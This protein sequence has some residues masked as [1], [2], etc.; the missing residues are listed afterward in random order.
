MKL[1]GVLRAVAVAALLACGTVQAALITIVN[2]DAPGEG[3]ND[4]TPAAPEGGNAGTT[5]GQQRFNLFQAAAAV[6][7]GTLQSNI[8]IKVGAQ[9]NPLTCS[10]TSAVL[11]SAGP[12]AVDRDFPGAPLANTWY[13]I[14]LAEALANGNRNG[15]NNEI[16]ATFNSSIDT[17]CFGNPPRRWWYGTNP[18]IPPAANTVSLFP[19]VLHELGHGLGFSTLVCVSAA[20]C[21][22]PAPQQGSLFDGRNDSWVPLLRDVSQGLNWSAMT[23]AQRVTSMTNDPN[24]VWN[25]AQVTAA[26]PTFAPTGAGVNGAGVNARMRMNA[27][28]PVVPG[29]S[30][31]HFT[32]AA[33]NPDLLME[34]SLSTGLFNQTDMTVPLF[35]DIGWQIL[36]GAANQPPVITRPAAISVTEDVAS[37]I[38]GIS[39]ADPD[40][41]GGNLTA[42]F[43]V[44]AGTFNN[45][46]CAGVTS[47]GT[48]SAR[49]LTGTLSNLN[50]CLGAGS[51]LY[52][53]AADATTSV[54]MTVTANDN[55]NTGTGGAQ[56]DVEIVSLNITA[57]NDPPVNTVPA[58]IAVTEDVATG[59]TGIS[60][61]DVDIAAGVIMVTLDVPSGGIDSPVCAG[62]GVAGSATSRRLT[63]TLAQINACFGGANRPRFTTAPN[64]AANVQL[65]VTSN[66]NGNTGT[67]N[68]GIDSDPLTLAVSA[69]NDA[70]IVTLPASIPIAVPGITPLGGI[71]VADVDSAG[72]NV[73]AT[74]AVLSG[75]LSAT[76]AGGVAVAGSSTAS[77][78]LTGTIANLAAF[79]GSSS[80]SYTAGGNTTLTVTLNDLGNTGSGGPQSTVVM[81]PLLR[82]ILFANSFE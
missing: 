41:G 2:L 82:E 62:V 63:G 47:G 40:I 13:H 17:G 79:L 10:Q 71:V 43:S 74:L 33:A 72:G 77:V 9:F 11:G 32:S 7:A 65:T 80:V 15:V 60:F 70:P 67:G 68:V 12:T 54:N 19:V 25:G 8:D 78:V 18:G 34:P 51:F 61:A 58:S 48:A 53:T 4:T 64:A 38:T 42:T 75:T 73:T 56:S 52:T 36:G 35:R 57:V 39:F 31:S 49:T 30:V 23:D 45:P 37:S 66:D 24:L 1:D 21:G 59:L 3:F 69:V 55:G 29:S 6:W 46:G 20:G 22:A 28:N 44:G 14:A 5:L 81:T 27:P 76:A 16:N 26:I 50:S